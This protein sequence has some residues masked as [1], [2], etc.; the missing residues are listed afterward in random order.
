VTIATTRVA[1][2]LT[3]RSIALATL[4][5]AGARNAG[6][7]RRQAGALIGQLA[8]VENAVE[9]TGRTYDVAARVARV[10]RLD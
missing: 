10:P 9:L 6:E 4:V 8:T 2:L 1:R 3:R 7:S 5:S